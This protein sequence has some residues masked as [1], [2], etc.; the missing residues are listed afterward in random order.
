MVYDRAKFVSAL[1]AFQEFTGLKDD[2]WEKASGVGERTLSRFRE[3]KTQ[4]LR[5]TTLEKLAEGAAKLT[6]KTLRAGHIFGDLPLDDATVNLAAN[7][8]GREHASY[9]QVEVTH[10]ATPAGRP[11]VPVWASAQ[12]GD[13]GALVLVPDPIDY[14]HRSER[15]RTVKNPFAFYVVGSSMSPVIEHGIQVVINPSLPPMPG[16]DHVFIQDLPDGNMKAMVKRLLRSTEKAWRVRQYNEPKDFDL[17]RSA[18]SKA[19]RISEKRED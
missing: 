7:D 5:I 2:P 13:D 9:P 1:A 12:A 3:G 19:Y 16:R 15:M 4:T 14:I 8:A 18:W 10:Q 6:G 11:D 17:P